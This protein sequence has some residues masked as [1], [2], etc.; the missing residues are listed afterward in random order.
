MKPVFVEGLKGSSKALF[1]AHLQNLVRRPILVLTPDQNA[2]E[3]LLGDLGY[4]IGHENL[5]FSPRF[6]P[7]WELLPYENLSPLREISGERLNVLHQLSRGE[8]SFLVAPVEAVM[9]Y[10]MPRSVLEKTLFTIQKGDNLDREVLEN[11]LVD[12]GYSR[13]GMVEER[14]Q[15]S[16]RGDI[17]DIFIPAYED[18]VRVEFFGDDVES[19]RRFDLGSQVSIGDLQS[20]TVL[21]VREIYLNRQMMELGI[22]KIRVFGKEQKVEPNHILECVE[23]IRQLEDFP[24]IEWLAPFFHG[25]KDSLFDYLSPD[26]LIVLDEEGLVRAKSENYRDLFLSEFERSLERG[27]VAPRPEDLFLDPGEMRRVLAEKKVL[28]LNSL[29][30]FDSGSDN[31]IHYDIHSIPALRGKFEEFANFARNWR[32]QDFKITVVAPTKGH[33]SRIH[34]LL[35]QNE[36]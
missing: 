30:L 35:D 31:A 32:K 33:V 13:S 3:T 5:R 28:H 21:P 12:S 16:V 9:Q 8:C 4:F 2:G 1:L 36:L 18:P 23:Q 26:T 24:G 25:A 11:C 29:K 20:V 27:D 22:E 15:F 6:F 19:L 17:V 34:E 10:V 7:S 14:G